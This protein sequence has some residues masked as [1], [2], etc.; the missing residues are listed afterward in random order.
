MDEKSRVGIRRGNFIKIM[1]DNLKLTD[2][3]TLN[4]IYDKMLIGK[5][6]YLRYIPID[7]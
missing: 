1:E 5:K 6:K 7:F 2:I 4:Q 3:D